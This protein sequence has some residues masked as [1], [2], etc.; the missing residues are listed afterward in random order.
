MVEGKVWIERGV[1]ER[2]GCSKCVWTCKEE[3]GGEEIGGRGGF[4]A[5]PGGEEVLGGLGCVG[6]DDMVVVLPSSAIG[7][8]SA[9]SALRHFDRSH[10]LCRVA[11]M[12]ESYAYRFVVPFVDNIAASVYEESSNATFAQE[13][14]DAIAEV[15]LADCAEVEECGIFEGD[16]RVVENGDGFREFGGEPDYFLW[17]EQVCGIVAE[18][19][20]RMTD[21]RCDLAVGCTVELEIRTEHGDEVLRNLDIAGLFPFREA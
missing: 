15:A 12:L 11:R 21:E 19:G 3:G 1:F 17:C 20:D 6:V 5:D 16:V 14:G 2:E 18:I 4:G 7:A 13:I 10:N 8:G 9:E